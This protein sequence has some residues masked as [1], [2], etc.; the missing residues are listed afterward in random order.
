MLTWQARRLKLQPEILENGSVIVRRFAQMRGYYSSKD[1]EPINYETMVAF[2]NNP[3]AKSGERAWFEICFD[4]NKALWR[5]SLTLF[6]NVKPSEIKGKSKRVP[7]ET[8]RAKTLNWLKEL[9]E[10]IS[11]ENRKKLTVDFLGIT[12]VNADCRFWR[13]ERF[14]LPLAYLGDDKTSQRLFIELGKALS[15]AE[16]VEFVLKRCSQELATLL[17]AEHADHTGGR[18]PDKKKDVS[19]L[20]ASFGIEAFYWSRLETSFKALMLALPD[21][22]REEIDEEKTFYGEKELP[23]WR[24]TLR[25]TAEAALLNTTRSLD[26][27]ARN[28]KAAARAERLLYALLRETLSENKPEETR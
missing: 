7:A 19:P 26:A 1:L 4:E 20:A 17:L 18:Q 24:K 2:R 12:A 15:W 16:E 6:Q 23:R 28:L 25:E 8:R 5:D 11:L 10:A 14:V 21:D 22:V 9:V 3:N 13:H 27:S